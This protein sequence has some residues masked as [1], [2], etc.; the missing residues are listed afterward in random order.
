MFSKLFLWAFIAFV[1]V[2]AC[3]KINLQTSIYKENE[4]SLE[5]I[6][7]QW[8]TEQPWLYF[9]WT[10]GIVKWQKDPSADD[11]GNTPTL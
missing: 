11:S 2:L 9:Y 7:P 8:H 6:F 5:I 4:N 1:A 3:S 10:P